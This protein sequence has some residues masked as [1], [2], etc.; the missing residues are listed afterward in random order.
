M[1]APR[2]FVKARRAAGP[3]AKYGKIG[4]VGVAAAIPNAV[5]HITSK[6]AHELPIALDKVL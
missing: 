5:F 6:R 4:L 3:K 1:P 2:L